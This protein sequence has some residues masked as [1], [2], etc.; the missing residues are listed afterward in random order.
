M[1]TS[2]AHAQEAREGHAHT[3]HLPDD[4]RDGRGQQTDH[5]YGTGALAV[6]AVADELRHRELAE[7]AQV[8]RQQHGQQHVAAGPAHQEEAPP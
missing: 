6:E 3:G 4:V 2:A 8:R 7:L 5:G 1:P